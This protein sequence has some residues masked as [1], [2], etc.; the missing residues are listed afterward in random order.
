MT[1]KILLAGLACAVSLSAVAAANA[2]VADPACVRANENNTAAGAVVG[3]VAGA[4]LGSAVAGRHERAEGAVLGGVGGA[5]V[6]G[7]VASSGNHPCP[8]GYVYRAPPP[9]PAYAPPPRGDFWYGAPD[10]V[11]ERIDFLQHRIDAGVRN[12]FIGYRDGRRFS[13]RLN[14]IRRQEGRMRYRDGG[15]LTPPD[16]DVLLNQLGDLS[17]RL[18]WEEHRDGWDR[19]GDHRDGDHRDWDRH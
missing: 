6:G 15:Q 7:V 18:H 19:D 14:D 12:G 1:A 16:R 3:G 11:R 9:P 10:G 13:M 2:Q 4:I 8:A 5:V 17:R